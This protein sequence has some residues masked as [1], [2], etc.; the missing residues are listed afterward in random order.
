MDAEDFPEIPFSAPDIGEEEIAA[1]VDCMRSGWLT[2]GP[3][4]K[5]FEADVAAFLGGGV[6]TV[7][8]NSATAGLL[9]AFEAMGL[10]PGDEVITTT[11]TFT[12]TAMAAV[13]LGGK[14]VLVDI[15]PKT[16]N[17]DPERI[18]LAITDKTKIIVP[19]H[20]GGLS[21]DMDAI[22]AIARPRGIK[23]VEDAAHAIPTTWKGRL[24]GADSADATVYSFYANKTITTGEGGMVTTASQAVADRCRVMRLHG[25]SRDAF[26]RY[27]SAKSTWYYEIVAPGYKCNMTDVAAAVGIEQLKKARLFQARREVIA[28]RYNEA[29]KDLPLTLPA[30]APE[31]DIHAWHLYV[32]RLNEGAP[33]SRDDFTK[34]MSAAK[35]N[36]SV[37]YIPLHRHPYWK[38]ALEVSDNMFPVAT[39][40]F[41]RAVSL[42]LYSKMTEAEQD[43]VIS[44]VRKL[45][46]G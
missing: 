36:C 41:R 38:E 21:C 10:E 43:R 15:D 1:V 35:I 20:L 37:H 6:Q 13:H 42:P 12:A 2:T 31:G 25:M 14:P 46:L 26:D 29:F 39:D 4:A 28:K 32:V 34:A 18:K 5:Q 22:L 40:A 24:I 7:A 16:L 19:V 33:I 9:L 27:R 23:V 30:E 17:I 8:V 3:R 44:T 45:L 11:Y